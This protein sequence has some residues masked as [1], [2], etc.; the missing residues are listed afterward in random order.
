MTPSWRCGIIGAVAR[1]LVESGELEGRLLRNLLI[2]MRPKQWSKNVFVFTGV[3]FAQKLFE[4]EAIA[5]SVLAFV[6]FC[7]ASS[8]VYLANDV[9]DIERDRAHPEKRNR[10]LAAGRLKPNVA[11]ASSWSADPMT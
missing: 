10:P 11:I 2:S 4:P 6:L 5:K 1:P 7:L 9:I 3:V 8:A